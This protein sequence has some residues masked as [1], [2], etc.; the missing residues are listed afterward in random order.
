M[1]TASRP[2]GPGS[3]SSPNAVPLALENIR[4]ASPCPASWQKM[5]G[6]DR[7][8]HCQECKLNVYNLSEMTRLEAERLV[9][10]RE[11]R[12]CVRFYR[13]ADGTTL[14]RDCPKGLQAMIRRVSRIAGAALSAFISVNLGATQGAIRQDPHAATQNNQELGSLDVRVTDPTGAEIPDAQITLIAEK[15]ERTKLAT[16]SNGQALF[17]S[18]SAGKYSVLVTRQ[19]FENIWRTVEVQ[20]GRTATLTATLP[21][22]EL[23]GVMIVAEATPVPTDI[24]LPNAQ[25]TPYKIL[26]IKKDKKH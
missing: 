4:V 20:K 16:D 6:D 24:T 12:M 10:N 15:G 11:G 19:L 2:A 9:A 14:T 23:Q 21:L 7:V 22:V 17:L 5:T 3:K 1:E 8:R 25:L 13:R 18:V 26:P